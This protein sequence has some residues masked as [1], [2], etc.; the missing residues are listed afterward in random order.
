MFIVCM[1]LAGCGHG[2]SF[3]V[4]G[5]MDDG[6]SINLR[7]VYYTDGTVRTAL[8]AS[9]EGKFEFEGRSANPAAVEVYDN[10]YRLLGRFVASNG[11]DIGLRINRKNPYLGKASGNDVN[12]ALTEFYNANA[13]MLAGQDVVARN[14]AVAEYVKSHPDSPVSRLLLVTEFDASSSD[15]SLLADSLFRLMAP[16]AQLAD[17]AEPFACLNAHLVDEQ[18]H[19]PVIAITYK[20]KGNRTSTFIPQR[21]PFS[22]ISV[23]DGTHGRDSVLEALRTLARHEKGGRLAVIDLSVDPDTIAWA[24]TVR[25]DSATWAQGW[26]AGSISGQSLDRLG[27][28]AIP[29]FILTDSTGTQL[30]RGSSAA[31]IVA[32]AEK[33]ISIDKK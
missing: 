17:I 29:Y 20:S 5:T 30:W 25:T 4:K 32:R 15:A 11:E 24:R 7:F 12:L 6:S 10:D 14:K 22:V 8:T 9:T 31:E 13:D 3:R 1:L 27:I 19:T 23:S 28:S 16:E 21:T 33:L 2:D 18:A 26:V